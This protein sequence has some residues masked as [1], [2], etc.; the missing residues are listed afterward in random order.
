MNTPAPILAADEL[1]ADYTGTKT[2]VGLY[3]WQIRIGD[4]NF[5]RFD[6]PLTT[7]NKRGLERPVWCRIDD[8]KRFQTTKP[9]PEVF[10]QAL[11]RAL[12]QPP[13]NNRLATIFRPSHA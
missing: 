11:H 7:R 3:R 4:R 1:A 6:A 10:Y 9:T 13:K 5:I 8:R 2:S 12:G